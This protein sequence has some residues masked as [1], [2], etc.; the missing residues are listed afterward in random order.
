MGYE[1]ST[2]QMQYDAAARKRIRRALEGTD[3]E[4]VERINNYKWLEEE[5][6]FINICGSNGS[7]KCLRVLVSTTP[8]FGNK[9]IW[10]YTGFTFKTFI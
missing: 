5:A 6:T 4:N 9:V 1:I 10:W 8:S 3:L 2:C 7:L